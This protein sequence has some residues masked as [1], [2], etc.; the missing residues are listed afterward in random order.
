MCIFNILKYSILGQQLEPLKWLQNNGYLIDELINNNRDCTQF[1]EYILRCVVS[2][3]N[4]EILE[5]L[6]PNQ[7]DNEYSFNCYLIYEAL[8][9]GKIKILNY[10]KDKHI[11]NSYEI[12]KYKL[13]HEISLKWLKDNNVPF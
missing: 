13:K 12:R 10:L 6:K 1:K 2:I 4:L 3:E 11:L 9:Y 5:W 7:L 8:L